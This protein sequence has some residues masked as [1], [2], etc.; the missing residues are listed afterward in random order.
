MIS[1][2]IHDAEVKQCGARDGKTGEIGWAVVH[3]INGAILAYA[4]TKEEAIVYREA[5]NDLPRQL[6]AD[7]VS[8]R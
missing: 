5:I 2:T 8:C 6:R 3:P 1:P 4:D 7:G